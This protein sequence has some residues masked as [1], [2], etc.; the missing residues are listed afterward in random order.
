MRLKIGARVV[1]AVSMG[2]TCHS[3][4]ERDTEFGK[5]LFRSPA[6]ATGSTD[7]AT[8]LHIFPRHGGVAVNRSEGVLRQYRMRRTLA[9]RQCRA[10]GWSWNRQVQLGRWWS[11]RPAV[12]QTPKDYS[13][14]PVARCDVPEAVVVLSAL[15]AS[16]AARLP[17]LRSPIRCSPMTAISAMRTNWGLQHTLK[18]LLLKGE[19][20]SVLPRR[21]LG[22]ALEL[23]PR[24]WP[25]HGRLSGYQQLNRGMFFA[26]IQPPQPFMSDSL[27]IRFHA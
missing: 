8:H 27:V 15:R 26:Q 10:R 16:A 2:S 20:A 5:M 19:G 13:L 3:F 4:R 18:T 6:V 7:S 21:A 25:A 23:A 11:R 17:A 9:R 12:A 22:A 1:A 24:S 14:D